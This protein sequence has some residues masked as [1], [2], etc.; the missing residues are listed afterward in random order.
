M[1][2]SLLD[3]YGK[4]GKS[5]IIYIHVIENCCMLQNKSPFTN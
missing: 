4:K 2:E 5:H 1:I 3:N